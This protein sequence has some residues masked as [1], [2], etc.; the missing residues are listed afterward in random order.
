MPFGSTCVAWASS[1]R[2]RTGN[3]SPHG[4]R[5]VTRS[6]S[7]ARSSQRSSHV[8][9]GDSRPALEHRL[10]QRHDALLVEGH[11]VVRSSGPA[12]ARPV[13]IPAGIAGRFD[14]RHAHL[15]GLDVVGMRVAAVLVVGRRRRADGT[16]AGSAPAALPPPR[17]EPGAK[18]PSGKRR[19]RV[20]LRK[21][22]IEEPQPLLLHAENLARP[23]HLPAANLGQVPPAP[24]GRSIAGFSTEPASP[25]VHV[26]TSTSAPSDT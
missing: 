2:S 13:R 12:T 15:V 8:A 22:G 21:P 26:T 6:L 9:Y 3:H 24:S 5:V 25:P 4:T 16:R 23:L 17:P 10:V 14:R 1:A 11:R 20:T 19:R 7:A 18:Q